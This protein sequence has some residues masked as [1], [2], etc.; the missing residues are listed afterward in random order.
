MFGGGNRTQ[1]PVFHVQDQTLRLRPY[2]DALNAVTQKACSDIGLGDSDVCLF[3][4]RTAFDCVLRQKVQKFGTVTDNL[5][6]C[7]HHINNMKVNV[8]KAGPI[9]SDAGNI[10]ENYLDQF[11]YM[12]KSF[13]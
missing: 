3:E 1:A 6:H 7:S 12:R 5:G 11:H 9:R 2:N 10:L 4:T 8:E 13:V